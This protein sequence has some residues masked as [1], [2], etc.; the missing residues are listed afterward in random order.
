MGSAGTVFGVEPDGEVFLRTKAVDFS[1]EIVTVELK[2]A[3]RAVN[4][5][6]ARNRRLPNIIAMLQ[7][8]L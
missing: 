6:P 5:T 1:D 8:R 7:A 4:F 3:K 2:A